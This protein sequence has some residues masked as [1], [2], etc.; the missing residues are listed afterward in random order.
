MLQEKINLYKASTTEY[1]KTRQKAFF[2]GIFGFLTLLAVGLVGFKSYASSKEKKV[3]EETAKPKEK[4]IKIESGGSVFSPQ[5]VWVD[6]IEKEQ[7]LIQ[8]RFDQM[9]RVL[10]DLAKNKLAQSGQMNPN[11]SQEILDPTQTLSHGHSQNTLDPSGLATPNAT[12]NALSRTAQKVG[13]H[14]YSSLQTPSQT[15]Y[16]MSN[17][18][19]PSSAVKMQE[20][21]FNL[22]PLTSK[23]IKK[24]TDH[25]VPAGAYVRGRLTSGVVA[26]TAVQSSSNP[27]PVHIELTNLGNLPRGFK[28][29]VKQCFLIGSAYGDLSSERVLMRLETLSCVERRTEEIIE[30]EVDGFVTGEDGANGLRGILVDRSGPAMRN[31]FVGGFLSGMGGFFSQ[32]QSS[33]PAMISPGGI[34]NF[35]PMTTQHMLQGGAG[36]GVGNAMEKLS[37]FYI[38]RAEQ[39]QPVLEVEP[40]RLV[41][42]V[43]KKGFDMNQTVYRQSLMQ[44]RDHERRQIAS[45]AGATAQDSNP[46]TH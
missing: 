22:E 30:M 14:A 16:G 38:K 35:N 36:K 10:T 12:N 31:A 9:E 11:P 40:G 32:Q 4:R 27:Q 43:F 8:K 39:L 1:V 34:A 44:V 7:A 17:K 5:E 29:D 18:V 25:Y 41:H 37:D 13:S 21:N 33:G 42:V 26:S 46:L 2:F 3:K 20:V 24:S 6:R 45:Q 23:R 28:T 19:D 15:A